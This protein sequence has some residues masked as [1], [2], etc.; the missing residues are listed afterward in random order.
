MAKNITVLGCGRWASFH[1]WYQST[2]LKNNVIMWGRAGD[3]MYDE[4][5]AKRENDFWKL[6][7]NVQLSSDLK[8]SLEF[9]DYI[10][11]I[12]SAQGMRDLTKK[13]AQELL[14]IKEHKTFIL[15]MK[16]IDDKTYETLSQIMRRELDAAGAKNNSI[17]VWVGPGH[18]QEFLDGQPGVMIIDGEDIE[19]SQR[20]VDNFKS[21]S[22]KLYVGDDLIGAE[23]GASAKN[24]FGIAAGILDGAKLQSLK[25]ALMARGVHEVS[26]LIVAM[27]GK[28]Q[29]AYGLSHLGDFEATLFSRN[30]NNRRFGEAIMEYIKQKKCE[31]IKSECF[32]GGANINQ[33]NDM[34]CTLRQ[35]K[36]AEGVATSKALHNLAQKYNVPMPIT[37]L[38]YEVLHKDKDPFVGF[39]EIFMRENTSEFGDKKV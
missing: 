31:N 17:C 1:S 32:K 16:G 10:F 20:V 11:I 21:A 15:C 18:I 28:K 25:G 4:L 38:V 37:T 6:P 8:N 27:G 29:T 26:K 9:S 24:V 30:S 23:V 2:V 5:E 33:C 36:L 34:T 14:K 7:E 3:P 12:I 39:R 35:L 13:I 22:M 19:I